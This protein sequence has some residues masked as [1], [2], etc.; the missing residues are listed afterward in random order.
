MPNPFSLVLLFVVLYSVAGNAAGLKRNDPASVPLS[1]PA[2]ITVSKGCRRG[3]CPG[4]GRKHDSIWNPQDDVSALR[5]DARNSGKASCNGSAALFP[6][7]GQGKRDRLERFGTLSRISPPGTWQMTDSGTGGQ[8]GVRNGVLELREKKNCV[9]LE[10]AFNGNAFE[11]ILADG[12]V[13]LLTLR[14][15]YNMNVK[16]SAGLLRNGSVLGTTEEP[17]CY[18]FSHFQ[19]RDHQPELEQIQFSISRNGLDWILLNGGKPVIE[20]HGNDGGLR[21]PFLFRKSDG[22]FVMLATDLCIVRRNNNWRDAIEN[23]SRCILIWDSEDLVHWK[24]KRAVE[25]PLPDAT[26]AWAPEVIADHDSAL[27]IWSAKRPGV[28]FK[29]YGAYTQDFKH[30]NA[31]FVF[32]EDEA[33]VID[34]TVVPYGGGFLRF[35]KRE[36]TGTI[37]MEKASSLR[38]PWEKVESESL[39]EIR[40]VEGPI[41][42][43]LKDGRTVL[44]LDGYGMTPPAYR[45][46]LSDDP[47]SGVFRSADALFRS[48]VRL[49]HGSVLRISNA[50]YQR[51]LQ[52]YPPQLREK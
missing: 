16:P 19:Y 1:E 47:A 13:N 45:A 33:D 15:L 52:A 21:D 10:Q 4:P 49:K 25:M 35:T 46:F 14:N 18:L 8:S 44:L 43:P 39:R 17:M 34:T 5:F 38:G 12:T 48:S 40:N 41:C 11:G 9:H 29:V 27:V 22:S 30:F 20:N 37:L 28:P 31:P 23:G 3:D 24:N 51:L 36:K 32:C 50:E 26:C 2:G 6:M 42:Y 7:E